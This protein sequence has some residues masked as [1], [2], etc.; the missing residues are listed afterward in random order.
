[1]LVI[2]FSQT[3]KGV[4][5]DNLQK[6]VVL[7]LDI[8]ENEKKIRL[9]GVN[10]AYSR[11]STTHGH[12]TDCK[13]DSVVYSAVCVWVNVDLSCL[14]RTIY[15]RQFLG[16]KP[17]LDWNLTL[18]PMGKRE[19]RILWKWLMVKRSGMKFG[20]RGYKQNIC[21]DPFYVWCC[22]VQYHFWVIRCLCAFP[23]KINF[24]C[25]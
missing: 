20:S 24:K 19:L 13:L 22:S 25:W 5:F 10:Q 2:F 7:E 21:G 23:I 16:A 4:P 17:R 1:M 15:A 6:V 18:R 12:I 3:F 9:R 14:G 11:L 8:N